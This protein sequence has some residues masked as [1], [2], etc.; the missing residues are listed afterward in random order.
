MNEFLVD[1]DVM[2]WF[3]RGKKPAVDLFYKIKQLDVPFCSPISIV[4]VL[5]DVK[6][7]EEDATESFL[8]FFNV[9]L[10]DREI[11][12]TA[13]WLVNERKSRGILMSLNDAIIVATCLVGNLFLI[14]YNQKHYKGIKGLQIY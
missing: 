14:T 9:I 3:L 5:S 11:A 12:Q 10:V 1:S 2:I 8:N 4:E 6:P 7:G 13:G